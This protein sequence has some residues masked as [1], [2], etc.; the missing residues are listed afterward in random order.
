MRKHNSKYQRIGMGKARAGT[1]A[2]ITFLQV[3]IITLLISGAAY[4]LEWIKDVK[5]SRGSSG[6]DASQVD[7]RYKYT[8][9]QGHVE[10]H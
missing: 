5:D 7:G 6:Y 1:D 9:R 4:L 10:R 3:A 2:G 8:G